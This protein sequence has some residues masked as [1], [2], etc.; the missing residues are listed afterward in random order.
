MADVCFNDFL[1]Y[2]GHRWI[3]AARRLATAVSKVVANNKDCVSRM[4]PI[5]VA[6]IDD[7]VTPGHLSRPS[8]LEDGWPFAGPKKTQSRSKPY[9]HSEKGHGTKMARL[10]QMM[11]PYA[12]LYVAKVDMHKDSDG[13]VASEAAK[14]SLP[15]VLVFEFMLKRLGPSIE[16]FELIFTKWQAVKWAVEKQ[17]DIISMSWTVK[18]IKIGNFDNGNGIVS[19]DSAIQAAA[20]DNILMFCAVQD[21]AHYEADEIYPS[22]SDTTKLM[23]VGSADETGERSA[24]VKKDSANYLFPGEISLPSI[25]DE[26]DQGSSVATAVAAGMAAM[27]LWCAEYHSLWTKQSATMTSKAIPQASDYRDPEFAGAPA[28]HPCKASRRRTAAEW[29]FRR[30]RRMINLFNELKPTD[31]RFVDIT[32]IINEVLRETDESYNDVQGIQVGRSCAGLFIEKCRESL[33]AKLR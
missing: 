22:Q 25:L 8:A 12:S 9:Y 28:S 17:V 5:K 7:G 1:H 11:C 18:R 6:I 4:R 10:I 15:N 16:L 29:D 14:V 31:D 23:T 21:G 33:P 30:D 19:L 26:K 27:I 2:S 20:N 3:D 24:F 13:S 32:N